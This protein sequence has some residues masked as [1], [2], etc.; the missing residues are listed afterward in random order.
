MSSFNEIREYLEK[1]I[2]PHSLSPMVIVKTIIENGL[3]AKTKLDNITKEIEVYNKDNN[4]SSKPAI[5][6]TIDVLIK[7]KIIEEDPKNEFI[8]NLDSQADCKIEDQL[9]LISL[10]NRKIYFHVNA[11]YEPVKINPDYFLAGGPVENWN[12]TLQN[13][14]MRWGKDV[15]I[16]QTKV[17]DKR[18]TEAKTRFN[19]SFDELT[20]TEK[21]AVD[22]ASRQKIE[23]ILLSTWN[24]MNEGGVVFF[25]ADDPVNKCF[26]L[27]IIKKNM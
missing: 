12:Y 11:H 3:T 16:N 5:R 4:S 7:N 18:E 13:M 27:G 26:G 17:E 8:L 15:R 9:E 23:N 14:P 25:R 1:G 2:D 24:Q 22:D 6:E 19:K 20:D 21:S 10:C